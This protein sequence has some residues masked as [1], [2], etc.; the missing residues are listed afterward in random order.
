MNSPLL[1]RPAVPM[2]E[3][4]GAQVKRLMPLAGFRNYD[5][6]VLFDH[7]QIQPGNGFPDHPHRGFEAITYLFRGAISHADN[8]GNHSTVT[9][10]GAQRFTAGRGLVHS[11]MPGDSGVTE[12]IQLWI[13]LPKELKAIEPSYQQADSADIP[14][15]LTDFG[16]VRHIVDG[17]SPVL[18]QTEVRYQDITLRQGRT[19]IATLPGGHRGLVYVV[20]GEMSVNE[21]RLAAGSAAFF[22]EIDALEFKG[23]RET[24][25]ML[26]H[27]LPHRQEIIQYG[28]FVD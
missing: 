16:L 2:E 9:P 21:H 5:P 10:G 25:F 1:I 19:F 14:E 3:G 27:G 11:E 17:G 12:G 24:R 7:F 18:L 28:P 8:L 20:S 22:E 6:F 13:N 4:A 15:E 26:A 23:T